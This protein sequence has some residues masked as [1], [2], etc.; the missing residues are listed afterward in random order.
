[1]S[2]FLTYIGVMLAV[3]V[4]VLHLFHPDFGIQAAMTYLSIRSFPDPRP[5]AFVLSAVVILLSIA[6]VADGVISPRIVY[7]GG[8]ALM[9]TYIIG[10]FAWHVLGHGAWWPWGTGLGSHAHTLRTVLLSE[11][12]LRA[13]PIALISIGAELALIVVLTVLYRN[14]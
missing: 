5:F 8:I 14:N 6:L 10:Y 1:M 4:A 13:D 11:N 3:I 2:R 12:H 7:L 9:F